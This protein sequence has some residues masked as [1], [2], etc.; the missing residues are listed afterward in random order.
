MTNKS[1]NC[2]TAEEIEDCKIILRVY[3]KSNSAVRAIEKQILKEAL[4]S[5]YYKRGSSTLDQCNRIIDKIETK[6]GY[7]TL[8]E[9]TEKVL[10]TLKASDREFLT[11]RFV[12]KMQFSDIADYFGWSLRNCFRRYDGAARAFC[13]AM[14]NDEFF[15]NEKETVRALPL[16]VLEKRKSDER[17]AEAFSR[18]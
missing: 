9:K 6:E 14:K 1:Q 11:M 16:Y 8:R 10:G 5:F 2:H 18:E 4:G 3:A 15:E 12:N 13:E 7:L 17:R